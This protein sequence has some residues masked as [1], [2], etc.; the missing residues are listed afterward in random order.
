M[1]LVGWEQES[2]CRQTCHGSH[3]RRAPV[4][5]R[6]P[7]G[8]FPLLP[9]CRSLLRA[10]SAHSS[11][12]QSQCFRPAPLIK[13]YPPEPSTAPIS[14]APQRC[15]CARRA[16]SMPLPPE[17]SRRHPGAPPGASSSPGLACSGR[18]TPSGHSA[19]ATPQHSG[20]THAMTWTSRLTQHPKHALE[21]TLRS[22]S[23]RPMHGYKTTRAETRP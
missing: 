2:R 20:G 15:A 16:R 3:Q 22:I 17:P 12:R 11:A 23:C 5:P 14:A 13:P 21:Q 1:G 6:H 7:G 18:A 10:Q 4:Q 19:A 9:Q 8:F